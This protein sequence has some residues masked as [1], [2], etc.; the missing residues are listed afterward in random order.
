MA[1]YGNQDYTNFRAVNLRGSTAI[2]IEADSVSGTIRADLNE[3]I[4]RAWTFPNKSGTF[5]I[6]GTFT[7]NVPAISANSVLSTNV[8]VSGI[9]TEDAVICQI[10]NT[11]ATIGTTNWA[12]RGIA[13]LVGAE[14]GNGGMHLT[15]ANF[16]ATA[17]VYRD[18]ILGYT[19][20]R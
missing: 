14:A 7:V 1:S 12:V 16:A 4:A 17:T 5:G 8:T 11:F 19:A 20:V 3:G 9:R 15:F 18:L 2:R 6:S 10:Q 13:A